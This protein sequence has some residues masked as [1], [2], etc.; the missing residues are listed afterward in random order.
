MSTWSRAFKKPGWKSGR[1]F[2]FFLF[3]RRFVLCSSLGEE[4]FWL[5]NLAWAHASL[6]FS[7]KIS[8]HLHAKTLPEKAWI[9]AS[10]ILLL[11]LNNFEAARLQRPQNDGCRAHNLK[12]PK[13]VSSHY[14]S[15]KKCVPIVSRS[16]YPKL[17]SKTSFKPSPLAL[18]ALVHCISSIIIFWSATVCPIGET[19]EPL[20]K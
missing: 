7:N 12:Y 8:C 19:A 15:G 9:V 2:C 4:Q 17:V 3:S 16:D 10:P 20:T 11:L 5:E 6:V 1:N 14:F 13:S 18:T